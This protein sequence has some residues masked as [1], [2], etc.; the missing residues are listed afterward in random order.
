MNR[1]EA[2]KEYIK[3]IVKIKDLTNYGGE[4]PP[5]KGLLK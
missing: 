4:N 3:A 5:K 2:L 1:N